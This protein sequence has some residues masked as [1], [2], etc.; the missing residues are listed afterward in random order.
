MTGRAAF[1]EALRHG[2]VDAAVDAAAPG[3]RVFAPIDGVAGLGRVDGEGTTILRRAMQEL[4][5]FSG[6][7]LDECATAD[8]GMVTLL[9][10]VT[11]DARAEPVTVVLWW[12][13]DRLVESRFYFDAPDP[14]ET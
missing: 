14:E 5:A 1:V 7:P 4:A 2:D 11:S 3:V 13:E 10:L 6:G 9:E 8:D 12:E